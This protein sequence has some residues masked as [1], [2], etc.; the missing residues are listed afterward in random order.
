[1]VEKNRRILELINKGNSIQEIRS[2]LNISNSEL[3]TRLNTLKRSGYK[4]IKNY[5]SDGKIF[6][7]PDTDF[8]VSIEP[9]RTNIIMKDSNFHF[10]AIADTHFG[11]VNDSMEMIEKLYDYMIKNRINSL[12]IAGDFIEGDYTP[13][14]YLRNKSVPRQLDYVIKNYPYDDSIVNHIL[15]GNHDQHSLITDGLDISEV[16]SAKRYDFDVLGYGLHSL[17]VRD[18]FINIKH[19]LKRGECI[20]MPKAVLSLTGHSHSSKMRIARNVFLHL[21]TCSNVA[22]GNMDIE[23][24]DVGATEI[25]L[26]MRSNKP[27]SID[28]KELDTSH[29]KIK[30]KNS[31]S[32]YIR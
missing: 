28:I 5:V 15:L 30:V 11:H 21:P 19:Q 9:Y 27:K 10:I 16:L 1:M 13:Y 23:K 2:K 4:F 32:Y 26:R 18:S 22:P 31:I 12:V 29:P 3:S 14:N 17:K 24:F 20:Q 8:D 25:T 7:Y 6:Y